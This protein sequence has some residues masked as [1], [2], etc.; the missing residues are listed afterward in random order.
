MNKDNTATKTRALLKYRPHNYSPTIA[1]RTDK[2]TGE[3]AGF[4]IISAELFFWARIDFEGEFNLSQMI[5][6]EGL[7][8][9]LQ[10]VFF[11]IIKHN[12]ILTSK[13]EIGMWRKF[14]WS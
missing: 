1:F 6:I 8:A 5:A 3:I 11:N 12:N 13:K 9:E 7:D 2:G 4:S 14:Q 10:D